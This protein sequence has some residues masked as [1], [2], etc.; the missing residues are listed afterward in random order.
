MAASERKQQRLRILLNSASYRRADQDLAFL[1]GD[2]VRPIRLQLEL[3]KAELIQRRENIRSTIVVFG[4][5][6]IPE[7]A[8]SNR[9]LNE[10][11]KRLVGKPHDAARQRAVA[12][13]KRQV[14]MSRY[15]NEARA[16]GRLVTCK[17]QSKRGCD[18]VVVTGG[19]PGIIEAANRGVAQVLAHS[20]RS[21]LL[22]NQP[23]GK[24][25]RL[26]ELFTQDHHGD[27]VPILI[28]QWKRLPHPAGRYIFLARTGDRA[29]RGIVKYLYGRAGF[30]W[31]MAMSERLV[32]LTGA[33]RV[34][35]LYDRGRAIG[36][37]QVKLS[38]HRRDTFSDALS[39]LANR[40]ESRGKNRI[41]RRRDSGYLG[42][43]HHVPPSN[44][45]LMHNWRAIL[46]P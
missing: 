21:D 27:N 22:G 13:A 14:T 33:G 34:R 1:N 7:P 30:T 40:F 17:Y 16:F 44:R 28:A 23:L 37:N 19:G 38:V 31:F 29:D 11:N 24:A 41:I 26:G 10:A 9:R 42:R 3:L 6:R 20:G 25:T 39:Q 2:E 46:R 36:I 15:Y 5:A 8:I 18:Y 45:L 12:L 32:T 35:V 43:R 4:S